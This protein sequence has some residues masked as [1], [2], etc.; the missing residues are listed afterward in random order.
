MH[1]VNVYHHCAIASARD[2]QITHEKE[3]LELD[4]T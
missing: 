3:T 1:H 2:T 4:N